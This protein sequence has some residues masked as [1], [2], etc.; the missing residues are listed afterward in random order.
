MLIIPAP[1]SY[2]TQVGKEENYFIHDGYAVRLDNENFDDTGFKDE[3]QLQ[4]YQ[5]AREM[6]DA[7]KYKS[8]IDLGCGSGY[9]LMTNFFDKVTLGIDLKP[10]IDFCR[11]KWAGRSWEVADY[12]W[13]P[14]PLPQMVIC[15]DVI[16]HIVEPNSFLHY[17]A[18]VLQP[19]LLIISTPERDQLCVG[20]HD[21]PPKNIHHVREWNTAEFHAFIS[22]WFEIQQHFVMHGTQIVA[23]ATLK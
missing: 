15:S 3:Y 22:Q 16:E 11:S 1:Y 7:R 20:T 19:K 10:A 5:Y 23:A 8:V 6:M 9:K 18:H 4:V 2:R 12:E 17:I 13:V 21:G 14:D